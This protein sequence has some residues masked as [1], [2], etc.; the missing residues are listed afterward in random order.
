MDAV[1]ASELSLTDM[2]IALRTHLTEAQKQYVFAGLYK[3]VDLH[4]MLKQMDR[5]FFEKKVTRTYVQ[6]I[7]RYTIEET[8]YLAVGARAVAGS[9]G[10]A[11]LKCFLFGANRNGK[12]QWESGVHTST[13]ICMMVCVGKLYRYSVSPDMTAKEFAKNVGEHVVGCGAAVA[14][15]WA[16]GAAGAAVGSVFPA[17][18]GTFIGGVFGAIFFM[19]TGSYVADFAARKAYR[20]ALPKEKSCVEEREELV[21][22][23]MSKLEIAQKAADKFG[24]NLNSHSFEEAHI[25][26][27]KMLLAAH[28][29]KH[30]N[31]SGEH[32]EELTAETRDIIACWGIIRLH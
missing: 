18:V 3:D 7:V 28:P 26:F 27:R 24:V 1:N 12:V 29:D 9:M 23:T 30:P 31:A 13:L 11:I 32:L 17:G 21:E 16:A 14:G 15:A 6:E 25:R 19:C 8:D 22:H 2:K 10:G 20:K 4:A 5:R